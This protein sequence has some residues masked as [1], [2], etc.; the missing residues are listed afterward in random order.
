MNSYKEA[1]KKFNSIPNKVILRSSH[2]RRG[3]IATEWDF[4]SRFRLWGPARGGKVHTNVMLMIEGGEL[5]MSSD[6]VQKS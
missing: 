6:V 2:L 5:M 3:K 4:S 1:E